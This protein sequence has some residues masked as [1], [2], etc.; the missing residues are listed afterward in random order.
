MALDG[1]SDFI[2]PKN[3]IL[4]TVI[5]KVVPRLIQLYHTIELYVDLMHVYCSKSA[6]V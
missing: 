5:R 6:A 3:T 2:N 4:N 1:I